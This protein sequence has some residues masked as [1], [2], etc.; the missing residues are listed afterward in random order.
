RLRAIVVI[1]ESL[2]G[3]CGKSMYSMRHAVFRN[4]RSIIPGWILGSPRSVHL[5]E[6]LTSYWR[7]CP[8]ARNA[9]P[10]QFPM[11]S[12][13]PPLLTSCNKNSTGLEVDHPVQRLEM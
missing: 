2:Q 11:H 7:A 13:L 3:D 12:R 4:S 8:A 6:R 1:E 9:R 5:V 10:Q